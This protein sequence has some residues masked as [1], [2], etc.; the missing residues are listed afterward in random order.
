[1]NMNLI[2]WVATIVILVFVIGLVGYHYAYGGFDG[3]FGFNNIGPKE[4]MIDLLGH[5]IEAHDFNAP[6]EDQELSLYR[7]ALLSSYVSQYT[8]LPPKYEIMRDQYIIKAQK[9]IQK[10][11]VLPNPLY[12][13]DQF[14]F[15][16]NDFNC[17][18]VKNIQGE[19][20]CKKINLE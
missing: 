13:M 4:N 20:L 6:V 19:V 16:L 18:P 7:L 10:G 9:I 15:N 3:S 11:V 14:S 5:D 8:D 12:Q 2:P 1:M 17:N